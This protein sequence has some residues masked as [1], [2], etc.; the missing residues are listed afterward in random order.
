MI[1]KIGQLYAIEK[2]G[3]SLSAEDR[4]QL[5]AAQSLPLLEEIRQWMDKVTVLYTNKYRNRLIRYCD[6]GQLKIDNNPVENAIRPFVVG[7]KNWI[8]SAS[9]K[10]AHTS[11]GIYSIIETCRANGLEPCHYLRHI[12]KE[13]PKVKAI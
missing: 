12:F 10:G 8:F 4:L 11:A 3:K 2:D 9:E 1:D 5:R 7:R 13:L 6:D